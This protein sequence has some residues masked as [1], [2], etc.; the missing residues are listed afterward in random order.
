MISL[1]DSLVLAKAKLHAKKIL[2][3]STI[4]V[5]G[6][7][8]ALLFTFI[9]IF[10]GVTKSVSNYTVAALNGKYLVESTP[11]IPE[12]VSGPS[13][14]DPSNTT[15]KEL[16]AL[17]ANYVASQKSLSEKAGIAFDPTA[18]TQILVPD[19]YA[20]QSL[21]KSP[22]LMINTDSP[23]FQQYL[24]ELQENYV[25]I[26][27][28]KL[29]DLQS[30]AAR[31]HA[32]SYHQNIQASV[33]F[34]TMT[35]L[36]NNKEDLSWLGQ[37]NPANSDLSVYGY[38][39]ASVQNSEYS[40][41]DQSFVQRFI[42]PTNEERKTQTA[43]PIPAVI[44][45]NEALKLFG[46]QLGLSSEPTGAAQQVAWMENL[47]QKLNGKIYST[48][49]RNQADNIAITQAAQTLSDIEANKSNKSY[50]MPS[51]IYNLPTSPCGGLTLKTDTRTPAEKSLAAQQV[52]TD[53]ILGTYQQPIHQLIQF[54][55]VGIMP[56]SPPTETTTD[57]P[58]FIA[59][60]LGAQYGAGAII[61]TEMYD[62]LPAGAQYK[63][64]L[65]DDS[66]NLHNMD[67]LQKAGI[68]DTIVTFNTLSDARAFIQE[69]GCSAT[70]DNCSKP[71]I[72]QPYGANYLLIDS[73]QA[74][75]E[76]VF[77]FTFVGVI[78]VATVIIWFMMSRVI[79]DSRRETAV[80]RAIGAKRRDIVYI[81][82]MYSLGVALRIATFAVL[83]GSAIALFA[84]ALFVTTITDYARASY[85]VFN[86]SDTF[87]IVSF[88]SP[89][90]L[91]LVLCILLVSLLAVLPSLVR[92]VRRNP[93]NDMR[94][95]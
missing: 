62:K 63:S 48:C 5:S 56:T 53:K 27:K 31:Y 17:Q 43:H 49:Y 93:I 3:L 2:L 40:F 30:A 36:K 37:T 89:L 24:Q 44:T 35:Y 34:Q 79:T 29:V 83:L 14:L 88:D 26:A 42:L 90:L 58:S 6:L 87:N 11:V 21:S 94:D 64:I 50:V 39:T 72:L 84:Q 18:I 81:Y 15:V 78:G 23:V 45:A 57:V 91:W 47:Q 82:L 69:Q 61:P 73:L 1:L 67:I 19:P 22:Q 92:N 33:S 75:I 38:L 4:I 74:T 12:D 20:S 80:F 10:S 32:V 65:Q 55:I 54:Q 46:T 9:I 41:I 51:L 13:R 77:R 16:N 25:K 60:L 66:S 28:N 52:A 85:G 70:Q 59:G 95:E 76:S 68:D 71:F 7:L 86:K 8:F